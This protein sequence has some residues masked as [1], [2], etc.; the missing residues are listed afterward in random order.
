MLSVPAS[1]YVFASVPWYSFLIVLGVALAVFLACREEK[2]A[3]LKK[4]TVV[5]LALW[6]LPAG[7]LGARLYYVLFSWDQFL[8]DPFSVFRIWEGGIAI[9]GAVLAGFVT[10]L[11]FARRRKLPPLLLCDLI[12]PGLALAQAVGR[13]GNYFNMEAY[14]LPVSR[15]S[16]CFF[17]LAV[18][19]PENG[20]YVWHLATFFYESCW[21][22]LIFVFLLLARRSLLRRR[23]DVFCCYAF[24]YAAG[25]FVIED[26][27]MDSLYASSSVRVSQLLSAALCCLLFLR[28]FRLLRRSGF[29]RPVPHGFAAALAFLSSAF[30]L[31]YALC[32]S[33]FASL[34]LIFRLALLSGSSGLLIL[35]FFLVLIPSAREVRHAHHEA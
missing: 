11:L 7:I 10:V 19:I 21:D 6:L 5:D 4:D 26:L 18:Q 35:A 33:V 9:Y 20:T 28:F 2:R 27:R 22:F 34:P 31:F 8:P 30:Q 13:W 17:P 3:G 1:R 15:A 25:R 16:L 32:P 14:G 29:F 24:L 23:G 12:A